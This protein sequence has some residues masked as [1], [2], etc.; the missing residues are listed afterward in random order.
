MAAAAAAG[1]SAGMG[2]MIGGGIQGIGTGLAGWWAAEQAAKD[3]GLKKDM[4]NKE[5]AL[6]IHQDTR[7]QDRLAGLAGVFSGQAGANYGAN[8][9]KYMGPSSNGVWDPTAFQTSLQTKAD[10]GDSYS[11]QLLNQF[12]NAG[13]LEAQQGLAA[14]G[15]ETW[16]KQDAQGMYANKGIY[17]HINP[18]DY[19]L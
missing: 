19:K 18:N 1:M 4:W 9:S 2:S 7:N 11:Q 17:S 3:R 8:A 15:V 6:S 5:T 14:Q 16:A 10:Q 12:Q 13:S